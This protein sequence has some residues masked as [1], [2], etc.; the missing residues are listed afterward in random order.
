MGLGS[1]VTKYISCIFKPRPSGLINIS[2]SCHDWQALKQFGSKQVRLKV[3]RQIHYLLQSLKSWETG[4]S[5][6]PGGSIDY[7]FNWHWC[8][9]LDLWSGPHMSHLWYHLDTVQ[10]ASAQEV[11]GQ[12]PSLKTRMWANAQ[13]DG[14]PAEYNWR[15]LFNATKLGWH[16]LLECRAV[17][18]PKR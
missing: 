16:P 8:Q 5:H 14:R 2:A 11:A 15:P 6:S 9:P 7:T 1:Q 12:C 3:G 18:K 17:M 4:P 10:A 13:R